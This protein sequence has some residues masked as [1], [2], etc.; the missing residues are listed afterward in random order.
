MILGLQAAPSRQYAPDREF[1]LLHLFLDITP[2]FAKQSITGAATLRLKP[3]A[4]PLREVRLDAV[5]LQVEEVTATVGIASW[6]V[7][8][9]QILV[10]LQQPA[11]PGQELSVT[12]RYRAEPRR[13]LYFRTPEMGY[14]EG[15]AHLFT[16]GEAITARHWYPSFD[17][18]NER[19]TTEIVCH[20]PAGMGVF[21]NGRLLSREVDAATQ[22]TTFRWLQDQPHVNYLVTLVAGPFVSITD[23]YR[24]IPLAFHVLPSEAAQATNSFRGTREMM[25]FF[26]EETGVLY[27][28]AKYDQI[29]VNDFVAGG[30]ENT[31]QTTLTDGT[32]FNLETENLEDSEGLVAH[33]LAHQWFGDLVTCKDWSHLWLNEGFATYYES[34][35]MG[36][37]H[38]PDHLAYEMFQRLRNLTGNPNDTRPIVRRTY[39]DPD[40]MFDHLTYPKASWV[41]HMIRRQLGDRLYRTCVRTYLERHRL[42]TVVTEDL[43]RILEEVSGRSWDRFFDQW[44]YH[45]GYPQ[46]QMSYSY[47][48]GRKLAR[49]SIAQQQ[50]VNDQVLLFRLPLTLRFRHGTTTLDQKVVLQQASQDFEVPCES[51]PELVRVDPELA[52]LAD[53]KLELPLPMILAQLGDTNDVV[54]RLLA[55]EALSKRKDPT[56]VERL[57]QVLRTDP[58]YGVRL[59]AARALRTLHTAAALD[60]LLAARQQSDARVRRQVVEALGGFYREPAYRA[61]LDALQKEPNPG[62]QAAALEAIALFHRPEVREHLVRCLGTTTYR[63]HLTAAALRACRTFDDPGLLPDV[64]TVLRQRK[65]ELTVGGLTTGLQTL[66]FL[67]RNA[68]SKDE[69]R[70]FLLSQLEHRHRSLPPAALRALG[71]LGDPRALGPLGTYTAGLSGPRDAEREAAREAMNRLRDQ[72]PPGEDLR[73]LRQEVLDLQQTTRELREQLDQVRKAQSVTNPPAPPAAPAKPAATR[74]KPKAN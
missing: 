65:A 62:I 70:E 60:A 41:L 49:V 18:P 1:D 3:I 51:P 42:G 53:I 50:P 12:V 5:D 13:G 24:D 34:L 22:R 59:E 28:W 44:I 17:A 35:W 73:Q 36:H 45:G 37:R 38:G 55:V 57:G 31:S 21:A 43:V 40:E 64:L 27:P 32:L 20:V 30:M 16:Q 74:K 47:D 69:V 56:S 9:R 11:E 25:A 67:A 10:A 8:P 4:F 61:L 71:T 6:H 52:V 23:Q 2:D 26:E 54:G 63:N 33:E 72:R 15:E 29:C 46:L 14:R 7:T 48:A 58:F 68:E 19:F 66:G 39:E